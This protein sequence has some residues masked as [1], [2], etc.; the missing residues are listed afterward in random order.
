MIYIGIDETVL[1][2]YVDVRASVRADGTEEY[3]SLPYTLDVGTTALS[4]NQKTTT[5]NSFVT[6]G[7]TIDY[8]FYVT[9]TGYCMAEEV[10]FENDASKGLNIRTIIYTNNGSL[11][12]KSVTGNKASAIIRVLPGETVEITV[13]AVATALNG[14]KE[15]TVTNKGFITYRGA[16]LESNTITHIVEA[17]PNKSSSTIGETS[18]NA[19]VTNT[20]QTNNILRTYKITGTVWMD[21]NKNGARDSSEKKMKGIKATL[22]NSDTGVI[23]QT[24]TTNNDGEY[25]FNGVSNGKYIIIFDYD[26]V[27]YTATTYQKE[28]IAANLNSDA[29]STKIEQD[30]NSRNGAVT[31]VI[32]VSDGSV[33]NIDLGLIDAMNFDLKLDMGITKI[34]VQ[35]EKGTT[36]KEYNFEKLTKTEVSRKYLAG[37]EIYI[38]YTL[39]VK[40][41]GEVAGFAKKIVDY[42]PEGMN[43]N[44][45]LSPS[46]Y[47]GNDGNLYTTELSNTEIAPGETKTVKLVLSKTMTSENTGRVSNTAEIAEDYN[48]YGISDSDS[49]P[50]NNN[51][52]E[53]DFDRADSILSVGTGEVFIYVSVMITTFIL[54]GALI[55]III[56]KKK[57]KVDIKGG[58]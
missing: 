31:H 54:I 39:R 13:R 35:N 55:F 17:N 32:Q 34:T 16:K 8:I 22:V 49:K 15:R 25:M 19:G 28:N 26:T 14:M 27:L 12:T 44:S 7:S 50:G 58:V 20:G 3:T 23:K 52:N 40:N 24:L 10:L 18:S 51:Q 57:N 48:I 36:S 11:V 2:K 30:G 43:F 56:I 1:R 29:I 53:D 6:E 47:T 46:W 37:S 9:N 38:E 33:S 42:I 41:E 5:L 4:I 21:S 45:R